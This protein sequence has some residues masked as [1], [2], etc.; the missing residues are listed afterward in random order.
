MADGVTPLLTEVMALT[1]VGPIVVM[2]LSCTVLRQCSVGVFA[3]F[4]DRSRSHLEL[5]IS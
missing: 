1:C 5:K 3:V 2:A 4:D